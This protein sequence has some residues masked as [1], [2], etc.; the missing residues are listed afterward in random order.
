MIIQN[1]AVSLLYLNPSNS[2]KIKEN[3]STE[4]KEWNDLYRNT[5]YLS[6]R[7]L[8]IYVIPSYRFADNQ[9]A[10][11]LA[12]HFLM[13]GLCDFQMKITK[14]LIIVFSLEERI[15]AKLRKLNSKGFTAFINRTKPRQL[16][17]GGDPILPL[18]R[19][20]L[21]LLMASGAING[22]IGEGDNYHLVQGLEVVSKVVESE[23]KNHDTGSKTTITKTRIKRDISV[24]L[25]SPNGVIRKLV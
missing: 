23:V 16:V 13:L 5:R 10:R 9:I 6:E 14:I 2:T 24:K 4:Q 18:N 11:F 3:D 25:I 20:Q 21:S 12:S 22:E 19:G 7:G 8:M 17:I 15:V 1:N